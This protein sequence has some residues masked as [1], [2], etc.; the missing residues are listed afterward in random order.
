MKV[1]GMG[2]L[3]HDVGKS[4]IDKAI[5][6]KRGRLTPEEFAEIKKHPEMGFEIVQDSSPLPAA[7]AKII[8]NHHEK[9]DG[10][11]YPRGL[12]GDEIDVYSKI[13]CIVDIFDALTTNRCYKGALPGF[14]ALEI[15]QNEMRD[16]VNQALLKE[17]IVLIG[18]VSRH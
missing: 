16:Q 4:R 17:L 1:M 10:S 8:L 7:G 3:L 11:G 9:C 15:M 2:A 18:K 5:L 12:K 14:S 13:T 6:N